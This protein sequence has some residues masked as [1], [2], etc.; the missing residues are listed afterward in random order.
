MK[1]Y[2][3]AIRVSS[4]AGILFLGIDEANAAI[5]QGAKVV[6]IERGEV[7]FE[8]YRDEGNQV[9][10]VFS[11]VTLNVLMCDDRESSR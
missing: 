10:L 5:Q 2:T 6:G 7:L 8:E 11:G 9:Q 3:I 4:D 1:E